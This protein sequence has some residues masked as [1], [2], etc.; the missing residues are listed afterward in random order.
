MCGD[1]D[2]SPISPIIRAP[3]LAVRPVGGRTNVV[4]QTSTPRNET[5]NP[6]GPP[7][8]TSQ[9]GNE[10]VDRG[11]PPTNN[12]VMSNDEITTYLKT[13][14]NPQRATLQSL[15]ETIL[16]VIP[17]AEQGMSYGVPAFRLRG[18]VV[19]GFAA[20]KS[21]VS[22]L[23]HSGSVFPEL[24]DEL[25]SFS[26]ATGA[27]RFPNDEPLPKSLVERLIDVRMAQAFPDG[28]T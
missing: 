23:P 18:K 13:L 16:E 26:Y 12:G 2:S 10:S 7:R 5:P 11:S 17:E 1:D 21:H 4:L 15:R 9:R 25:A 27:L 22:Y 19:A 14:D 24:K 6:C 8:S 28:T 3:K 20:F